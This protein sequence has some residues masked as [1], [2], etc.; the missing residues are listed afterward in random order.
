MHSAM[1]VACTKMIPCPEQPRK[2]GEIIRKKG[3]AI[4]ALREAL[5]QAVEIHK[6]EEKS[7]RQSDQKGA[8][9]VMV[10][11]AQAIAILSEGL[12]ECGRT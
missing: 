4:K 9:E 3:L 5:K 8:L 12:E 11:L 10:L 2:Q 7:R 1:A 6:V